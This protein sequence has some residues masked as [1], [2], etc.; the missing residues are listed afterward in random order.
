MWKTLK[1]LVVEDDS[2]GQSA[3]PKTT[4]TAATPLGHAAPASTAV[5]ADNK[6]VQALRGAIKNRATAFT[7]LL[8]AADKLVTIIPDPTT[9]LKAAFAT[10]A[11][12]GR[13]V[14]EVLG[15]LEIHASDLEGQRLQFQRAAEEAKNIA[16]G[17]LQRELDTI[18]PSVAGAQSQITS[19]QTQIQ[20]LN[21]LIAQKS[22]RG[23][24]LTAQISTENQRLTT[25]QQEFETA[26]T[27]VKSELD[28]QKAII[29]TALS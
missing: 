13:G 28:G 3:A 12:E 1:N 17:G 2:S 26:L 25:S 24:E 6:F 27:I 14:K 10:V 9:R 15:A 22:A 8:A 5:A 21:E 11:G 4:T 23:A 18:Q 19:M 7:S 29:L 20:S 16:V